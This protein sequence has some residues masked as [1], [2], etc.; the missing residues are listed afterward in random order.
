VTPP[1]DPPHGPPPD[2]PAGPPAGP[3]PDPPADAVP[4]SGGRSRI[5]RF[6]PGAIVAAAFIGPGT[7]TTAT[8]AGATHGYDL[9]WALTFSLLATLVL[10]E[11]AARL[12]LV[13]GAGLGEAIRRRFTRPVARLV[14]VSMVIAAIAFGNAAYETGNLLGAALGAEAV[15]GGAPRT[16]AIGAGALAYLLLRTGSYR[17][18]ERVLVAM[19]GI[20]AVTFLAT[21]V[22][23]RPP[24]GPL[25]SGLLVPTIPGGV[26]MLYVA[27]LIGT[28]VV[29]YNLFL[30]A[31]VVREK[32]SGPED[33]PAARMDLGF[34][35]VVGAIVSMA[36]VATSAAMAQRVD[37]VAIT[38]AADMAVQLEPL[39][40]TGAR[41]FFAV[42]LLAAGLTSAITAPLAAAYATAGAL[43]W[44]RDL[45][46]LRVRA[47]WMLV[48]AVGIVFAG[49][50]VRPVPAILF[51]QVANGILLP[52]IAVFLLLAVNDRDTMGDRAN[53]RAMNLAGTAVVVIALAL[54]L[55]ALWTL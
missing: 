10:Q 19:V 5:P 30:H 26:G 41:V 54:G 34:S 40:G 36:I 1:P 37:D 47:V 45:D 35:I 46:D 27:G 20:M 23:V 22:L 43:G 16:W 24:L 32:W 39:L 29:P 25:L 51:A 8:L 21:A 4:R 12:G 52:A 38:G 7:V 6:G 14:A 55:R 2:P 17:V 48:L 18:V 44:P 49:L 28:T 42:G 13:S 11:M 33:L 15:W 3:P 50:G 53:G 31:A 9:L